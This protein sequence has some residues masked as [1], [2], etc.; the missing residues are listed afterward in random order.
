M[1]YFFGERIEQFVCIQNHVNFTE[2]S[3]LHRDK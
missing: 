2:Y 1:K 3:P